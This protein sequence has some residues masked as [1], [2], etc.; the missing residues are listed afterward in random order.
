[1]ERNFNP[2]LLA[3]EYM[4]T[5]TPL[6]RYNEGDDFLKWQN[7]ARE[8]LKELLG[9]PL[10]KCE[11]DF[12]IEY[13]KQCQNF[14][15]IRFSF[16]SEKGYYIPCHFLIPNDAKEKM[17]TFVCLQ[18]HS[19]GMHVS[20]GRIKYEKDRKLISGGDRDYAIRVVK[21]GF[22]ALTVEQRYMGECGGDGE[23]TGCASLWNA[24]P[25]LLVGRSAIG[26]RV[27]DTMRAIDV[28]IEKFPIVDKDNIMCMGNS[29]GG[30]ATFYV[31]CIDERIKCAIPSCS[32]CTYKD[33]IG[34]MKHCCCN[35]VPNIAKYFDMGDLGGLIAPRKLIVVAGKKDEIFPING[36]K[37][38]Y[39]IIEKLYVKAG[40]KDNVRLVIGDGG[41]RFYADKAY[42]ALKEMRNI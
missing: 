24:L 4:N 31:S 22:C 38:S 35:Y 1:M 3:A 27:W 33:S 14:K 32:V 10:E 37:E 23:E 25:S 28:L 18:G 2:S 20:L 19:P 30:T 17:P 34:A 12:K 39:E 26:E 29:G 40:V 16:Q 21:E 36:V 7:S 41:H 13:E 15:E 42:E 9:L 11:A 6:M 5:H 8:K